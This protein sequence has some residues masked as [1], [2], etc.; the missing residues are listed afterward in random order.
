[1]CF[2]ATYEYVPFRVSARSKACVCGLSPAEIVGSNPTGGMD[3]SLLWVFCIVSYRSLGRADHSS[4]GILPTAVRHCVWSA[5]FVN[6]EAMTHLGL[7]RQKQTN[8]QTNKQT[9]YVQGEGHY[10][11]KDVCVR[12][13]DIQKKYDNSEKNFKPYESEIG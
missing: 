9:E 13:E 5:K 2:I 8:K 1:M 3:V 12:T 4:R 7:S 10:K 11:Q 6:E